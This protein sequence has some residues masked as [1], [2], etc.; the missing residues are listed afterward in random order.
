MPIGRAPLTLVLV[1]ATLLCA[2]PST[3]E[4]PEPAN[5]EP[6]R[7]APRDIGTEPEDPGTAKAVYVG[8]D[9]SVY[10]PDTEGTSFEDLKIFFGGDRPP[11][12]AL[13]K[14]LDTHDFTTWAYRPEVA[15]GV[16]L[17]REAVEEFARCDYASWEE[18]SLVVTV[19]STMVTRDPAAVVRADCLTTL[20]W[21]QNWIH[22][23]ALRL[24]PPIK[25]TEDLVMKARKALRSLKA[26]AKASSDPKKAKII[27]GAVTV[28][29]SHPWYEAGSNRPA[30]IRSSLARPRRVLRRLMS[31][32]MTARRSNADIDK[33]LDTALIRV[34]DQVVIMTLM[35]GLA[36]TTAYV[37]AGAAKALAE[38]G[39]PR[40]VGPI[41]SAIDRETRDSVIQELVRA[42]GKNALG[43]TRRDAIPALADLLIHTD[44]TVRQAA[45]R[46][47]E[48][49]TGEGLEV[50]PAAWLRWWKTHAKEY[51]RR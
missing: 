40:A 24:D 17:T 15:D 44:V 34:N 43:D 19:L 4:T 51:G 22:D 50:D 16:Q 47:L 32:D 8:E 33:A 38:A 27:F 29:G 21:F 36:D 5:G 2:C 42:L 41:I 13:K 14:L 28:L 11:K 9:F 46:E 20:G 37:R 39:D 30:I 49:L 35:A 31:S 18:T 6:D 26:D 23:D 10:A 12:R 3:P 1:L 25:T 48:R 7:P 45:A